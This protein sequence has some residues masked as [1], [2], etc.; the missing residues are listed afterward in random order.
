MV[1]YRRA[2]LF[3]FLPERMS[4]RLALLVLA[5]RLALAQIPYA[6]YILAPASRTLHPVSVHTVNGTATGAE[7]VTGDQPG[8]LT[9][10][11]VSAVTFDYSKNIAGIVSLEIGAVS[12][13]EQYIGLTYSESS[14]WISSEG[15]DA[16]GDTPKDLTLWFQPKEAGTYT[17]GP[18]HERGAF[19]YLTLVHNTTG[20]LEVKSVTTH[21]TAMPHWPDDGLQ[22]YTGYFH[23][24]GT[25]RLVFFSAGS[26]AKTWEQMNFLTESGMLVGPFNS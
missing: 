23:S 13:P 25:S 22:A 2:F 21:F 11:D 20:S 3:I 9:F 18:E 12:D 19:K 17:L 15:S 6:E 16:M 8:S 5:A 10:T 1:L 4:P 7:S 24:E 26:F 14:L